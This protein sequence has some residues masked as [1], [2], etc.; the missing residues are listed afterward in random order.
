M[1]FD[2]KKQEEPMNKWDKKDREIQLAQ[3]V[4]LAVQE[5]CAFAEHQEFHAFDVE[6]IKKRAKKYDLILTELKGELK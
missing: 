6:S 3:A 4:N 1:N 2:I 5:L